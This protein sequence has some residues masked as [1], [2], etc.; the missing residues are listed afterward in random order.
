V[1]IGTRLRYR[2]KPY[3]SSCVVS[4]SRAAAVQVSITAE[5]SSTPLR[6]PE[7]TRT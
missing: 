3:S 6:R 4:A 1:W 2:E 7:P 5:I